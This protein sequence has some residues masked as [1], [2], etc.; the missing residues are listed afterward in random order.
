MSTPIRKRQPGL[1][2][3]PA[4]ALALA[5]LL[6]STLGAVPLLAQDGD[7]GI[8]DDFDFS[9]LA[10]LRTE[11]ESPRLPFVAGGLGEFF[12]EQDRFPLAKTVDAA[13]HDLP[14]H[15]EH[16]ACATAEGLDHKGDQVHFSADALRELGNRYAAEMIR[17]RT[18][19]SK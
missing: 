7:E 1:L 9:Q 6:L 16:T 2:Q 5:A 3:G 15:V 19:T 13:L 11:L 10:H 18:Q 12:L 14:N 4:L 17:L 8:P